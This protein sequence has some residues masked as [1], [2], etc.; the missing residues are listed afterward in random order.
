LLYAVREVSRSVKIPVSVKL[1]PFHAALAN[2]SMRLNQAGA[3][4]VVLFNRLNQ[5]DFDTGSLAL[6]MVT[7]L[8]DSRE[9]PLRT[10]WLSVLYGR[11]GTL[12]LAASG[13]VHGPNDAIKAIMAGADVVQV[14]ACL[15][16]YGSE[17]LRELTQGVLQWM[18]ENEVENLS[19]I[20][21]R[22]SLKQYE[23]PST[24]VRTNYVKTLQSWKI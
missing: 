24:F 12:S 22:M 13:G 1:S 10:H 21:G 2:L 16:R 15:Y 9:L 8:S 4:G 17:Y 18:D 19:A 5:P 6:K 7:K 3:R 11:C 23:D 14:V 20:Q